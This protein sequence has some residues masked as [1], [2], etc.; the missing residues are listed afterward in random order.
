MIATIVMRSS[1][2]KSGDLFYWESNYSIVFVTSNIRDLKFI[3]KGDLFEEKVSNRNVLSFTCSTVGRVG[4]LR[5]AYKK[6]CL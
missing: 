4:V 5:D 3:A 1:L 6:K 2:F